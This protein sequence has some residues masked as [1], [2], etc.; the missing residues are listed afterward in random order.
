MT[1]P[2]VTERLVLRRY[3]HDDIP[4]VL[5][6]VSQPSLAGVTLNRIQ[7]TEE[8]VRKYIDL[9]NSY[10]PFEKDVVF[11]LAV[12][13]KKDGKVIGL[14]GLI[15]QDHG[16][17]EIGWALGVEHRGQGYAT[18]AARAL[19]DYGFNSL[20]LHR[21]Y[22]DTSSENPASWRLMERLG[23]RREAL[24]RGS[25]YEEGKWLDK[26]IYGMLADEWHDTGASGRLDASSEHPAQIGGSRRPIETTRC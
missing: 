24:L 8:G 10:Q 6:F 19:M 26:Y 11:E 9:Q 5:G 14:L 4:D 18:E 12:E 17:G 25:V 13:R 15:C 22:A 23:M 1:L 7:A 2:I 16:Q 20:G 21:I 3:T